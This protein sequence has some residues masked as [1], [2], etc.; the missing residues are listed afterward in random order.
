MALFPVA[1]VLR[2]F[3]P[4]TYSKY[5]SDKNPCAALPIEK[6]AHLGTENYVLSENKN[7]YYYQKGCS[8]LQ[9]QTAFLFFITKM[10]LCGMPYAPCVTWVR[11]QQRHGFL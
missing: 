7:K 9:F 3:L 11:G 4:S 1:F 6:I 5:A 2:G 8:K 10:T